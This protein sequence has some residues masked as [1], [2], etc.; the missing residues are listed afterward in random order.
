MIVL[1]LMQRELYYQ[2]RHNFSKTEGA[3]QKLGGRT[4]KMICHLIGE[5]LKKLGGSPKT[6]GQN[7]KNH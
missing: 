3:A 7:I 6:G 1:F 2:A 4:L 5:N